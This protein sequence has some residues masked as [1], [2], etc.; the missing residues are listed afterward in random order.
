MLHVDTPVN[1]LACRRQKNATILTTVK[2]FDNLFAE[3][4]NMEKIVSKIIFAHIVK[5]F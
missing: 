4:N 1:Y 5:K 3:L 2:S